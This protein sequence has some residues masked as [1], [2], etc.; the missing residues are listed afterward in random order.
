MTVL[1]FGGLGHVGSWIVHD[2]VERGEEVAVFDVEVSDFDRPGLNYLQPYRERIDLQDVD[3]RDTHVLFERMRLYEGRIDAVIFGI[4]VIAGPNF[5]KRPFHNI[6]IN[7]VGMLNVLEICRIFGV[8]KFVN[9]SSGAV[10]GNHPGGQTESTPYLATDLYCATKIA[11]EV[12]AL[13]YGATYDID[14]RNARLFAIYGPGKFPAQLHA[15]YQALFGP[16]QGLHDLS[17]PAGRDQALDWTHVRDA[18]QGVI[19]V[20][21]TDGQ[22]GQSFNISSGI[23]V[24]HPE[25][26]EKVRAIVGHDSNIS[27]GP[28]AF[29][30]RGAPLDIRKAREVLGFAPKYTDIGDGLA[31]YHAWLRTVAG[32]SA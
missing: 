25:I 19:R 29:V 2:L 12:F 3:V 4:A 6:E 20:L 15:L 31:D 1:V 26:V 22:G 21:D 18:A 9:M 30:D 8:P 5:Q 32:A 28:G 27:L 10:Y 7:T 11:N 24:P 17:V 13:Q 23:A 16:L 14:V